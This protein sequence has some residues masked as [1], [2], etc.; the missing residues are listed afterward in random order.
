MKARNKKW[1]KLK[2]CKA[3]PSR[4]FEFEEIGELIQKMLGDLFEHRFTK[5]PFSSI[6][7]ETSESV[8]D[9]TV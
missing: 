5:K 3:K 4:V 8:L 1:K 9:E 6:D 7:T 2:K